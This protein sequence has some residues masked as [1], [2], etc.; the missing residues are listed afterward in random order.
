M[1]NLSPEQSA[2]LELYQADPDRAAG[3]W[4]AR[5]GDRWAARNPISLTDTDL[6]FSKR[7]GFTK[8]WVIRDALRDVTRDVRWLEVGCNSGAHMTVME[9]AGFPPL[10]GVEISLEAMQR[11]QHRGRVAQADALSLPFADGSFGGVTTAGSFMHLGPVQRMRTCA[12]ELARVSGRWIFLVELWAPDA[13]L[14]SFGELIPPVWLYP[15]EQAL[16]EL[17]GDGWAVRYWKNYELQGVASMRADM[18]LLLMERTS[19]V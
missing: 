13:S 14:V 15:W 9:A 11:G 10:T 7:Y 16:P 17:L 8:S 2:E 1:S 3:E 12:H 6:S 5:Q 18:C 4:K 19:R